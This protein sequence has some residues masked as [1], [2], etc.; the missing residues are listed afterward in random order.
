MIA[1]IRE[2]DGAA[3]PLSA[4]CEAIGRLCSA[5]AQAI[6]MP[7]LARL[8]G[9][10]HDMGKATK[11][12]EAYLRT[13][14][15][16]NA[17]ASPHHHAPTGAIYAYRRWFLRPGATPCVRA[18]AQIIMLCIL[19]MPMRRLPGFISTWQ[20]KA[21]WTRCFRQAAPKSPRCFLIY[22]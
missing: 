22:R 7:H 19:S 11:Q 2:S 15:S 3:Q 4:H 8:M 14:L 20:M 16:E 6:G 9:L 18:T 21:R 10:L 5:S 12:F 17:A 1:H 13:A